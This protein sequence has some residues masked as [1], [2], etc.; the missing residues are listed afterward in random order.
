MGRYMCD[1]IPRLA[2]YSPG[3]TVERKSLCER[4]AGV[5]CGEEEDN[6]DKLTPPASGSE[7][8]GRA[9]A[10][11]APWA[12]ERSELQSASERPRGGS[13]TT[14]SAARGVELG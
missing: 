6:P 13:H 12:R 14:V 11:A 9:C 8:A 5:R 4:I 10:E 7:E 1:R 3:F 2:T